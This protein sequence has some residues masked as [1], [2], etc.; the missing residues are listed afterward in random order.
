MGLPLSSIERS[1]NFQ[2][3]VEEQQGP[4]EVLSVADMED[5]LTPLLTGNQR[6]YE[7]SQ[8]TQIAF[9]RFMS[10]MQQKL[11]D[12]FREISDLQEQLRLLESRLIEFNRV[13]DEQMRVAREIIISKTK[14]LDALKEQ[15][16]VVRELGTSLQQN[17]AQA[18]TV[19]RAT[20]IVHAQVREILN[21]AHA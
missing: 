13:H 3:N 10:E 14:A 9:Q 19:E 11:E 12:E 5:L 15:L 8:K 20:Q 18:N 6:V 7:E 2:Q 16:K 1:G 21:R 4:M 17:V